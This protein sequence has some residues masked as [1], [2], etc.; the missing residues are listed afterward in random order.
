MLGYP[1]TT[2][3]DCFDMRI[4]AE[5]CTGFTEPVFNNPHGYMPIF[6]TIQINEPVW[7]DA[8]KIQFGV[9][10]NIAKISK[11]D[12]EIYDQ[13][14]CANDNALLTYARQGRCYLK[15]KGDEIMSMH[16]KENRNRI[17]V[18]NLGD[19]PYINTYQCFDAV[20]DSSNWNLHA[21]MYDCLSCGVP[22][23]CLPK[24]Q[25]VCA[26]GLSRNVYKY[27][28]GT[29][30][31]VKRNDAQH[32]DRAQLIALGK[33]AYKSMRVIDNVK[34][35]VGSTEQMIIKELNKIEKRYYP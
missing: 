9:I 32:I 16:R 33:E 31:E 1:N 27:T 29:Y 18:M 34:Q 15:E 6:K 35:W 20:L 10:S 11:E 2:T 5:I 14:L 4:G 21:T 19:Q 13:L 25:G 17:A 24:Q 7:S 22:V 12:V 28:L 23:I 26:S 8:D 30:P 3:L